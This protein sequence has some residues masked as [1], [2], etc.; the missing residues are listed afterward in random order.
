MLVQLSPEMRKLSLEI[1]QQIY[2]LGRRGLDSMHI[3]ICDDEQEE[4]L[5]L[6]ALV[7]KHDANMDVSLYTSAEGLMDGIKGLSCGMILLDIEMGGM[8]SLAAEKKL[9][10]M[11]NP[12]RA[13]M[14]L[15]NCAMSW[16]PRI[17]H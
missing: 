14:L 7:N 10:D 8:N 3:T 9:I 17:R 16:I 5:H 12:P 15:M 13:A 1:L 6:E 4:L 2:K 11:Q